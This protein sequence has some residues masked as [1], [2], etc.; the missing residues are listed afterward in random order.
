MINLKPL[1]QFLHLQTFKIEGLS[2]LK[3]LQ[4]NDFMITIDLSDAYMILPAEED[5]RNY[6]CF[7]FQDQMFQFCVLP[8]GLNDAPRAFTKTLKPPVGTL[9]SLGFKLVV[10]LD[11]ITLAAY[12]KELCIYQ[13]QILIKTLENLGFVIN[14]EKSNPVP[15]QVVLFLGF[16]VDSKK[17]SFSLPDSKIQSISLSAQTVKSTKGFVTKT[18]P[19]HW[20][21]QCFKNCSPRSTASLQID[22]KSVDKHS[23]ISVHHTTELRCENMSEQ[24]VMKRFVLV[25][26]KFENQL[27][28]TNPPSTSG[29]FNYVRCLRSSLG[30]SPRICKNSGFLEKLSVFLAHKQ[31]G[32]KNSLSGIKIFNPKS[33]K[34][35]YSNLHRQQNSGCLYKPFR[36]YKISGIKFH[37]SKNVGLV[38]RE[39]HVSF[40]SICTRDI[41]QD[42]RFV[43]LPETGINRMDVKSQNFQTNSKCLQN[44]SSRH[45]RILPKSPSC[46][47]FLLDSGST[48]C[49]N[50][51]IVSKLEQRS[52]LHVSS[53]QS[54]SK[55]SSENNRRQGDCSFNNTSLAVKTMVSHAIESPTRQASSITTQS[56]NI[57][58]DMVSNHTSSVSEQE[59]SSSRLAFVRRSFKDQKFSERVCKILQASWT[60][61]TEKQYQSAWKQFFSWCSQRS[62]DPFSCSLNIILDYLVDLFYKGLKYRIINLHRSAIS[63]T[64][65]P[66][67]AICVGS[68]PFMSRLMKGI[69]NL[70]PSCPRYVQTWDVSVVL[71]YLKYLS[72][73]PLLS[74]KNLT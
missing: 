69:F 36:G 35:S 60:P 2:D 58:T 70:R 41:E 12:T 66:V 25:G 26:K 22:P 11:N 8:F 18:K 53:L 28:K 49:G 54:D 27:F 73:A 16:I 6:L 10:Y 21:V 9:R 51:R 3:V 45:V 7:Q 52:P 61:G 40:G 42:C 1:N 56:T 32:V 34:C 62:C 19:V 71:R 48:S 63:M 65:L 13:G 14:P 31:K 55:M 74:M 39:E 67:D 23:K 15:S 59:V 30:S 43:I 37:C 20:N 44:S 46:K 33:N 5:S 47:V 29:S 72:P 68:H 24:S 38:S 17:M 4:P 50:G 57:E 64:H